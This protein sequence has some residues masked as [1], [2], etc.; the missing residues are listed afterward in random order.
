MSSQPPAI[1]PVVT[2][3]T[4]P[5]AT[6]VAIIG[7][8]IVGLM[9]ALTLAERGIPVVVLEKGRLAGEQSSRNLG[10]VRKTNRAAA[11]MPLSLEADRLWDQ[12]AQRVG[13]NVGY[14]RSGIMFAA[15]T[16]D[17]LAVYEDWHENVGRIYTNSAIISATQIDALAPGGRE[18]WAGA[19]YTPSDSCAEPTLAVSAI[20]RAAMA[21]GVRIV[22]NCAA[23][24]LITIGGRVSGVVTEKGEI[25]CDQVILAGGLWSRRFLANLGLHLPMLP[26]TIS[27]LR[28]APMDGPTDIATGAADFSF[29]RDHTGG[30]TIM[31][32]AGLVAPLTLDSFL[33]A[34]RYVTSIKAYWKAMRIEL[35][36]DMWID[37]RT[38]RRWRDTDVTPFERTR[39]KNPDCH[40]GINAEAMRNLAAAWPA[41]AGASIARSWAGM[42]DMTPDSLP[43]IDNPD[44]LPG[45]TIATGFS[46]HGFGSSPAAGQLAA[47]LATGS[48]PLVDPQPYRWSRFQ[49]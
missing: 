9:A 14:R 15:R 18:K 7:G 23:R 3:G 21:R 17:E 4:L 12:L 11:D 29:R 35:G 42:I 24:A 19:I 6:S 10:W 2:S 47:D 1:D 22:E 49:G 30:Y 39:T 5:A 37:L 31:H 41:F 28:T 25:S 46:G 16:A 20:A 13:G 45:L 33:L 27:V 34:P 43:V 38:A 26:L 32:R 36:Q 44:A 48:V 8:G 40:H